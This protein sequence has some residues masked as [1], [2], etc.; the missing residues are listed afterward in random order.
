VYI[1]GEGGVPMN[2]TMDVGHGQILPR[3]GFAYR[4][5]EKTV[6]RGGFGI[7]AD[8]NQWHYLRNSYPGNITSDL[9]N[10]SGR[11]PELSLT[12]TNAT[13]TSY[14]TIPVGLSSLLVPLPDISAGILP[15]PVGA[16]TRDFANPFRRG[17][18][19]SYN[20]TVQQ[21]IAG[22]VVEAGYVGTRAIRPLTNLNLNAAPICPA[23]VVP[24]TSAGCNAAGFGELLTTSLGRAVSDISSLTPFGN[25]YYDSLQAKLTRHIGNSSLIGAAYTF[26]KAIDYSDN[27]DLNGSFENFPAYLFMNRSLASFDRTHNLQLYAVYSLPFGRGQRWGQGGIANAIAGGWQLN[28]T[29]SKLSGTPFNLT[30]NA[31]LLNPASSRGF[32]ETLNMVN[33]F[34]V[35]SG[36]PWSGV[37]ICPNASCQ[38]FNPADFS[39]PTAG[40]FG[41][42]RRDTFRGP[43]VF[44]MD[45]S[46]FRDFKL[47]ERFTFQFR[48]EAFG[49]TNTP[50]FNNPNGGCAGAAGATCVVANNNFGTITGTAGT[51]GSNSS[52]DGTRN[53][54]FAG[55]LTF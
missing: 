2:S 31:G 20:L 18:I 13:G 47:T 10:A 26:S 5:T 12:G 19:N 42:V 53:I 41:D 8:P 33:P 34:Q 22:F 46:V 7:S 16:S 21:E 4:V 28:S 24:Y 35:T 40:N 25:N 14:G 44:D 29:V 23:T 45:L 9:G 27:D 37:G 54:W 50:R 43:G 17:Y 3:I 32:T 51:S 6:V 52:T 1:G 15:L 11:I 49:L 48:A 30:G 55:K 38:Y 39:Q 36:K